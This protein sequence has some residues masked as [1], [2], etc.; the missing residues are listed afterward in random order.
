MKTDDALKNIVANM[1]GRYITESGKDLKKSFVSEWIDERVKDSSLLLI[2]KYLGGLSISELVR[3][4]GFMG[5]DIAIQEAHDR[6]QK[7]LGDIKES[8]DAAREKKEKAIVR[9]AKRN[10]SKK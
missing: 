8:R 7:E 4:K 3:V 1:L 9:P 10:P 5:N 6:K 2:G